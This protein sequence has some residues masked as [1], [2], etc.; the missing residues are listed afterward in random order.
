MNKFLEQGRKIVEEHRLQYKGVY[1][2]KGGILGKIFKNPL[3]DTALGLGG[4]ALFGPE[5][6]AAILGPEAGTAATSALGDALIGGATGALGGGGKGA[7]EGAALGGTGGFATGGGFDSALQSVGL[8]T[9]TGNATATTPAGAAVDTLLQDQSGTATLNPTG[10]IN[11]TPAGGA[12]ITPSTGSGASGFDLNGNSASAATP[13][14]ASPAPVNP[15][16][17]SG[18][19]ASTLKNL[20]ISP[21]QALSVAGLGA[22]ALAGNKKTGAEINA[23]AGANA[24]QT[25]GNALISEGQAGTLPPGQLAALQTELDQGIAA[26]R[27]R[28]AEMGMSGSTSEAEAIQ[29][30]QQAM[31]ANVAQLAQQEVTTGLS[32]LGQGTQANAAI[33]QQQMQSDAGLSQAIAMLAGTPSGFGKT[34][35]TP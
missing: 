28:Y 3:V 14:A 4:S 12:T 30:A 26:I 21:M 8:P 32:A 18:G 19:F 27:S 15:L 6:G 20:G 24:A 29:Q 5:I 31:A 25:T 2:M 22:N 17:S 13:G 10:G 34:Q 35:T 11:I 9:F 23:A 7:L 1:T 33:A 16:G